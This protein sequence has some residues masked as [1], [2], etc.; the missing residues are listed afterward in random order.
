MKILNVNMS[1]DSVTGGG[2]AERTL[3]ISREMSKRGIETTILT[4]DIGL[5]RENLGSITGVKIIAL[6]CLVGRLYFPKF[7]YSSIQQ[8]VKDTDIIHLMCHWTFINALVYNLARKFNKPYVV[9]PAGALTIFGRSYFMKNLYNAVI[10]NRII[11]N[12]DGCIAIA[13]NEFAQFKQ[14]GVN[15][16]KITLIPNGINP[17]DFNDSAPIDFRKKYSL[18]EAPFLLFIG[19]LNL[20][21]GPGLLMRAFANVKDS[22]KDYHLVFAGSDGGM[23]PELKKMQQQFS[24]QD[25]VHFVG[26]LDKADKVAAYRA[27]ELLVIPSLKEAMSLVVL[28]AAISGKPVLIT[29]QCGFNDVA[30]VNGGLVVPATFEG[31][32]AGL[33]E[34]LKDKKKLQLMGQN[35]KVYVKNNFTWK[36]TMDKYEQL[37]GKIIN[38][39]TKR[40][41]VYRDYENSI[42]P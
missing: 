38:S 8:L 41:V 4:T 7:S 34:I 5:T 35:F 14:Y 25:R 24:L 18:S 9:C 20:M 19:R 27:T 42:E 2:T 33:I 16:E 1:I 31:I 15:A 3:Q 13:K 37:H 39:R 32:Q 30:D 11:S 10:G 36:V 22:L 26:H 29:D 40:K 12:A 28:E 23:L 21:K 17:D 6:P